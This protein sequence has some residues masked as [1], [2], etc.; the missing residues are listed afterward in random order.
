MISAAHRVQPYGTMIKVNVLLVDWLTE[1]LT[2]RMNFCG[3]L[4]AVPCS[5]IPAITPETE[6]NMSPGGKAGLTVQL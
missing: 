5:G 4:T 3:G 6:F 2:V 1:S